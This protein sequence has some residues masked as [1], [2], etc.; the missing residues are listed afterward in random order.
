VALDEGGTRVLRLVYAANVL[1]AAPYAMVAISLPFRFQELGLSV[2]DYGV[3]LAVYAFGMFLTEAPWGIVA[4]KL[5]SPRRILGV[6]SA[7]LVGFG[8]L[9]VAYDAITFGIALVVLGALG[10]YLAPLMRWAAITAGGPGTA[11]TGTGRIGTFF[12]AG[13]M[14]GT[15]AGPLVFD[16]AGFVAV[17]ISAAALYGSAVFLASRAPWEHARLPSSTEVTSASGSVFDLFTANFAVAIGVVL[18]EFTAFSFTTNFLPY[19]SVFLFHGTA[20]EAGYVLGAGRFVTLVSAYFLG[21]LVDRWSARG[22]VVVGF[23]LLA[24]GGLGTWASSSYVEMVVATMVFAF[25]VGWLTAGV[26]P[27]A[28]RRIAPTSHGAAIGLIGSVEDLGLLAGPLLY[29][30]LWAVEGPT[31][32]FPAVTAVALAGLGFSLAMDRRA[33]V[34]RTEP[35]RGP[36]RSDDMPLPGES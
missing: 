15:V 7:V 9:A 23:L 1:W 18:V 19:Y 5:A 12:M 14:V 35:V 6:G 36:A 2:W 4:A 34:E 30:G 28:L 27:L 21:T 13:M 3:V 29:A 8:I 10:V 24:A 26:L 33:T 20:P 16:S 32:I 25:G 31:S 17:A 11:G 22:T